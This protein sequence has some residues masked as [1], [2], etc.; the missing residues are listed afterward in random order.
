MH[1]D[2][3]VATDADRR[4]H[5]SILS[6]PA[7]AVSGLNDRSIYSREKVYD[8]ILEFYGESARPVLTIPC[9]LVNVS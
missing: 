9:A 5:V 3:I 8:V 7:A 1:T 6:C 2:K 4:Y